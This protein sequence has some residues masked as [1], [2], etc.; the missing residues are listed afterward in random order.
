MDLFPIVDRNGRIALPSAVRRQ[1]NLVP[2]TRL[3]LQ[4]VSER[5]ELTAEPAEPI[6][7]VRKGKRLVLP[8]TGIP[9]DAAAAVREERDAQ[10]RRGRRG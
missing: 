2:G 1:L 4:V 3:R 9:F 6:K 10:A 5:I 8:A 7:L